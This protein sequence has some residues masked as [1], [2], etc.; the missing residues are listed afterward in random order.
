MKIL[1]IDVGIKNLAFCL[2][3]IKDKQSQILKW[4]VIDLSETEILNCNFIEKEKKCSKPA[5][6]KKNCHLYC[7]KHAKKEKYQI[8]NFNFDINKLSKKKL[9]NLYDIA[10]DLQ[11]KYSQ[12]V[13]KYKKEE[14]IVII[15]DVI[16]NDYFQLIERKNGNKINLINIGINIQYHFDNILSDISSIEYVIIENQISPIA[17][18]MKNIQGMLVQYFIM[19]KVYIEQI[20]FVSACNKLKECDIKVKTKYSERKKISISKCLEIIESDNSSFFDFYLTHT[21]KD[22]LADCF[23]Q[24][25]WFIKEKIYNM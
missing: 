12:P 17:N 4:D 16:H 19:N 18:R 11:I 23:L 25:R 10:N 5:K 21:K 2:F 24:G 8:P 6:F 14:L 13:I 1:S 7:L 22:D 9:S 3:E 15:Q 20:E